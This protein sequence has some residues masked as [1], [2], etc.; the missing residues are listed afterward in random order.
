MPEHQHS[1]SSNTWNSSRFKI[2]E[3]SSQQCHKHRPRNH[4]PYP[5]WNGAEEKKSFTRVQRHAVRKNNLHAPEASRKHGDHT[6]LETAW[7]ANNFE[8][9]AILISL[10]IV[11]PRLLANLP[12]RYTGWRVGTWCKKTSDVHPNTQFVSFFSA[13]TTH[14]H[15][16]RHATRADTR[17]AP[18]SFRDDGRK[19]STDG[20]VGVTR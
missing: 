6:L 14:V 1:S 17:T 15:P 7:R 13:L 18:S 9:R 16:H 3:L 5:A 2:P 19:E 10:C 20:E 12:A 11:V 8:Q 4:A